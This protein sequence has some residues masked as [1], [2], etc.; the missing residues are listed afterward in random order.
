MAA[1]LTVDMSEP[2]HCRF[3]SRYWYSVS[4]WG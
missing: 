3:I 4:A 2:T 1:L